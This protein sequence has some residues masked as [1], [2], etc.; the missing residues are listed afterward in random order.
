MFTVSKLQQKIIKL[1]INNFIRAIIL[2]I[3]LLGY[4]QTSFACDGAD[5]E[6][7]INLVNYI[8]VAGI[9][10]GMTGDLNLFQNKLLNYV[11]AVQQLPPSCQALL[12]NINPPSPGSSGGTTCMG[13]VCCDATGCY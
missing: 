10:V 5:Y 12:N 13:G 4:G 1:T 8:M 7:T 11:Q 3:L 2:G 6:R 9:E